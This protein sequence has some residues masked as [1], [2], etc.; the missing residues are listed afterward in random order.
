MATFNLVDIF[1]IA[2]ALIFI[3]TAF[4]RGFV[5]EIFSLFNWIVS[6]T[7]CYVLTPIA[8]QFFAA[9]SADKLVIDVSLRIMIFM[10]TFIATALSTMSLCKAMKSKV[11]DPF[12]R[13]LGVLYGVIK[14]LLIFGLFYSITMNVYGFLLGKK[15]DAQAVQVPYWLA[16]AKSH[17]I[18][19]MSGDAVDPMVKIFFDAVVKNLDHVMPKN[20]LDQ[21]I[22]EV[23]DMKDK[24]QPVV[25]QVKDAAQGSGYT[26]KDI[27]KMNHLIDI[28]DKK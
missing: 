16:S 28:I 26:K 13:S 10:I 6:L 7:I 25:E 27:E 5:K 4:F 15:N 20:D 8:A 9:Y 23:I 3:L 11:P 2:F 14:T 12:D 24:A 21:K 22:D 19:K 17:G 1:F 18:L